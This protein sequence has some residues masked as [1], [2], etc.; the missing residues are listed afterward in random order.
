MKVRH[1]LSLVF[2]SILIAAGLSQSAV[3]GRPKPERFDRAIAAFLEEDAKAA[4]VEGGILF[5][6]SSSIR[7]WNTTKA[8]PEAGILNRGFGGSWIQD[9]IYFADK[10]LLPYKP[11]KVVL[12]A[13]DNDVNGGLKADAVYADYLRLATLVHEKLPK[14]KILFVAIKPSISRWK[15]WSKMQ[16]ANKLIAKR[17]SEHALEIFVDIAPL[18][19]GEDGKP[20]SRY[21]VKDGL[22]LSAE[23]YAK[24]SAFIAPLL[25]E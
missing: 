19:L 7:M 12:Y 11:A 5:I 1:A 16:R 25:K 2:S 22:H 18:L 23:G 15:L 4:P 10:I 8:F 9:T 24:W 13:G 14:T 21:F 3:G 17:C 6:G 20:D